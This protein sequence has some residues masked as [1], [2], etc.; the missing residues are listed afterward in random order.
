MAAQKRTPK[1]QGGL[2]DLTPLVRSDVNVLISAQAISTYGSFITRA[3][4]PLLAIIGL[5]INAAEA[6][7]LAAVDLIAGAVVSQ[8]AGVWIDRLPRKPVLIGTDLLR[9]LL[10]G[11]IPLA[12][13][14]F[15]GVTLPHLIAVSALCGMCATTFDIAERSYVAGLVNS[16]ALR[17]VLARTLGIRGAAEFFG[18]GSAGLLIGA[19]GG[20]AAIGID[21][22]TYIASAVLIGFLRVAEPKLPS[23]ATRASFRRELADG[24]KATWSVAIMRPLLISTFVIGLYFGLFRSSYLLFVT[25]GLGL[26]PEAIGLVIATGGIAAFLGGVLTER[27]SNLLGVGRAIS[28]SLAIVGFGLI[29]VPLAPGATVLGFAMLIGHQLLSDGFETVWEANQAAIRGRVLPAAFQG[30]A[31][32]ANDGVGILGRLLGIIV[33]GV[34]GSSVAGSGVALLVGGGASIAVGLFVAVSRLGVI[35]AISQIPASGTRRRA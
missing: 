10:L 20:P 13:A 19:F 34:I 35:Q 18:F 12:D 25:N 7:A 21:A 29:L 11:T 30:R 31:N 26:G 32:A 5:G 8:F 3:A 27:I 2:Q 33:G 23:A 4:L 14:L 15:G 1:G 6:A 22:L 9:A 17:A 16:S 24:L 28:V